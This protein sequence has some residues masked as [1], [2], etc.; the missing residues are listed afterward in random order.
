M[1]KPAQFT[2]ITG[3]VDYI[4]LAMFGPKQ[5]DSHIHRYRLDQRD[6]RLAKNLA[7]VDENLRL[8]RPKWEGVT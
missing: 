5:Y 2:G 4:L 1:T 8:G 3:S 6:R 7:M